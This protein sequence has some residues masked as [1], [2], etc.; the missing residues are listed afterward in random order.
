MCLS[1]LINLSILLYPSFSMYN[2]VRSCAAQPSLSAVRRERR[3]NL[4]SRDFRTVTK[5]DHTDKQT[6]QQPGGPP[7]PLF[8]QLYTP[9]SPEQKKLTLAAGRSF[10]L[11]Y[12]L[13]QL[14]AFLLAGITRRVAGNRNS[15]QQTQYQGPKTLGVSL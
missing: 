7:F 12:T 4:P 6:R 1:I 11:T 14:E 3:I 2:N 8:H 5:R 13:C 9:D 15:L 10:Y